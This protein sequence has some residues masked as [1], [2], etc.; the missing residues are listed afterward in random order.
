MALQTGLQV[1][2][3]KLVGFFRIKISAAVFFRSLIVTQMEDLIFLSTRM[4]IN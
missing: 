3:S 1:K 4:N 2:Q